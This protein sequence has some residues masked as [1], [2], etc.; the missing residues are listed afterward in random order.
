MHT[1]QESTDL[2]RWLGVFFDCKL[3]FKQ[4]VSILM[5]KALTV[6]NTL[7]SL[8]K[9]TCRVPLIFLQQA[10]I[11]CVL[12]KGYYAAETWWPGKTH[13]VNNKRISNQVEFHICKLEKV[14]LTSAQA[15]LL[16]YQTTQTAALYKESHLRLPEI[17]LNLNFTDF[18]SLHSLVGPKT[19]FADP[20]EQNH[21]YRLWKHPL[22]TSNTS[23]PK[24][25]NRQPNSV[26]PLDS[27]RVSLSDRKENF[28]PA[29]PHQR[30]AAEDFIEFLTTI[31]P[32]DIQ[33]FSDG[34][35]SEATDGTTGGG[36]VTF[37]HGHKIDRKAFSL[38]HNAEVFDAEAS[39][40]L[41]GAKAALLAPTAKYATDMWVFLDNLEVAMRLLA[42]STGSSQAVFKEFCEVARKWHLQ[43]HLP[44]LPPGSI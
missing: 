39:A 42:P 27:T 21:S 38:G 7:H 5:A 16:V 32:N 41:C 23:S 20:Y 37:Q 24:S 18:R 1:V 43:P 31:P 10:I 35:K 30:E 9:T 36:S 6:R 28:R 26:P 11:A 13:I 19:P 33:V 44:H 3:R 14:A 4:H 2:L 8:G 15:I 25:R 12:K 17:E 22:C 34:S 40:A 29:R